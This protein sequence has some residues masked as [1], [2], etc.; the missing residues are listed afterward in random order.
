MPHVIGTGVKWLS[1][2]KACLR[3][4]VPSSALDEDRLG[5]PLLTTEHRTEPS[6]GLPDGPAESQCQRDLTHLSTCA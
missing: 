3:E 5:H 6:V 4:C 2:P 1:G